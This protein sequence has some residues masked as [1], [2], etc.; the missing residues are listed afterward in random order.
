MRPG[1][2]GIPAAVC[3]GVCAL[4][5]H[6]TAFSGTGPPDISGRWT[7]DMP[8]SVSQVCAASIGQYGNELTVDMRCSLV[9]LGQL[10]GLIHPES[11][12]FTLV[13]NISAA[14][15]SMTGTASTDGN[16]LAGTWMTHT[17][18]SG[19]FTGERRPV[20][21]GDID[22]DGVIN[23]VDASVVLQIVSGLRWRIAL[24]DVADVDRDGDVN[25]IDASLILQLEAGLLDRLPAD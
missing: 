25:S 19:T 3:L 7:I 21:I 5:I 17:G 14:R 6:G 8:G 13:G 18:V 9:G 2:W 11:G 15:V 12:D 20:V 22:D 24:W 4:G 16:T 10:E 23:S 1:L